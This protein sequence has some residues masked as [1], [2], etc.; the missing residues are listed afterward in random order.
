VTPCAAKPHPEWPARR[1]PACGPG[2]LAPT[3]AATTRHPAPAPA[4]PAPPPPTSPR[5]GLLGGR[6]ARALRARRSAAHVTRRWPSARRWPGPA[7]RR[8]PP[9]PQTWACRRCR[10]SRPAPACAPRSSLHLLGQW[11]PGCEA[12]HAVRVRRQ[13][14]APSGARKVWMSRV[15][16]ASGTAGL[17]FA[18]GSGTGS[19]APAC[20]PATRTS[21][22]STHPRQMPG[23]PGKGMCLRCITSCWPG[24][25]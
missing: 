20:A 9:A 21:S 2:S 15:P 13:K 24:P 14:N 16:M 11:P 18:A 7:A 12:G 6:C 19:A 8:L 3:P 22:P 10:P 1:R 25:G 23:H 4:A 17:V 5:A